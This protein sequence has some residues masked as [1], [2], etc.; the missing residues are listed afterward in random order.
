MLVMLF[1]VECVTDTKL[2]HHSFEIFIQIAWL[3]SPS[4]S[5]NMKLFFVKEHRGEI[6]LWHNLKDKTVE[7]YL[8]T[9]SLSW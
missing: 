6:I 9:K 4:A 2:S 3:A 7:Q 8:S 5:E 1:V